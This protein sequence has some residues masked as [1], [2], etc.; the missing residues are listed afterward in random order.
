[1]ITLIYHSVAN[2]TYSDE[3][4]SLFLSY[5]KKKNSRLNITG[6]LFYHRGNILQIIE[7]ED[8]TVNTLF[9]KIKIDNRHINVIKLVHFKI[10]KRSYQNWSMAFKHLTDR[11][12]AKVKGYLNIEDKQIGLPEHS[13][14]SSY[15]RVIIDSFMN[16][17]EILSNQLN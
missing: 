3:E 10:T 2:H 6:V 14:K 5:I 16:E 13:D 15:L 9:E 11:D 17:N 7:G 4:L 8:D 12:W 1:M